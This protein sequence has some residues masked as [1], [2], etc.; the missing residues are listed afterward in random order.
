MKSHTTSELSEIRDWRS[1]EMNT[2]AAGGI[3]SHVP[4]TRVRAYLHLSSLAMT[5]KR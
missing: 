1:K 2:W 3:K 5:S 4:G